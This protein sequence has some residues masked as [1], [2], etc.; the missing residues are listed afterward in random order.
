MSKGAMSRAI[1]YIFLW[2]ALAWF[3]NGNKSAGRGDRG[4]SKEIEVISP[5]IRSLYIVNQGAHPVCSWVSAFMIPLDSV[6]SY[7]LATHVPV[8]KHHMSHLSN[9]PFFNAIG[10]TT[11]RKFPGLTMYEPRT[12]Y[13][14][15]FH[16]LTWEVSNHIPSI[17]HA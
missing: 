12:E 16:Y 6:G 7:E 17:L 4:S 14:R 3:W 9:A 11:Q 15:L 2:L 1:F 10:L 5:F 13:Q 8:H